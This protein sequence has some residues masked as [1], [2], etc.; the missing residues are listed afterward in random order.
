MWCRNLTLC[1]VT[2]FC[3]LIPSEGRGQNSYT[4]RKVVSQ[5]TEYIDLAS[6]PAINDSDIVVFGAIR[7]GSRG[8]FAINASGQVTPIALLGQPFIGFSK[9]GGVDVGEPAINDVGQ[10]A[11]YALSGGDSGIFISNGS[12]TTTAVRSGTLGVGTS[13]LESRFSL[14]N[15]GWVALSTRG[16][17]RNDVYVFRGAPNSIVRVAPGQ[18]FGPRPIDPNQTFSYNPWIN[19]QNVVAYAARSNESFRPVVAMVLTQS[20][21]SGTLRPFTPITAP[22]TRIASINDSDTDITYPNINNLGQVAFQA[23]DSNTAKWALFVGMG[24]GSPFVSPSLALVVLQTVQV[25]NP[26]LTGRLA[27]N[28]RG[29]LVFWSDYAAKNGAI[30]VANPGDPL[31]PRRVIGEGDP[32]DGGIAQIVE[33]SPHGLNDFDDIVFWVQYT[34]TVDGAPKHFRAIFIASPN[35]DLPPG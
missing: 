25:T 27:I 8:I 31:N 1:V 7:P 35:G 3:V 2:A 5:G 13:H 17:T 14:N 21:P 29:T 10:I 11:Y 9:I 12:S 19:D 30:F 34:K 6:R 26:G 18:G 16:P 20:I 32:I 33:F 28:D 24:S 23:I 22:V 15:A 4:F